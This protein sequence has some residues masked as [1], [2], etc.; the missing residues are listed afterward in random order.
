MQNR[1]KEKRYSFDVALGARATNAEV[2]ERTIGGLVGKVV[3]WLLAGRRGGALGGGAVLRVFF[4][5][6]GRGAARR[7]RSRADDESP[8][9]AALLAQVHGLNA[10]VFAYGATG[11]G[12]TVR[13]APPLAGRLAGWREGREGIPREGC[14]GR[15]PGPS[16]PPHNII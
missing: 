4:W 5:R 8:T 7:S 1:S 2:Y 13:A 12:K 11:S 15:A 14:Q 16:Q 3:R 10:T 6:R 9:T